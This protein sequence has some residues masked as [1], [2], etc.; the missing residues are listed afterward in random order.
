MKD[1]M[2][3]A[4]F[5]KRFPNESVCKDFI[6]QERWDGKPICPH[7]NHAK[8]YEIKGGMSFKCG[9]CKERFSVRTGTVMENSRL[10]LQTWL[11][12][13]Y[14][15]TTARKGISQ[16]SICKGIGR[17]AKDSMVFG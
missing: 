8:V 1:Y 6:I 14:M 15:M 7:C 5:Y 4:E 12:A 16:Y 2:S 17:Y 13:I 9:G 3:I 11:L 10:K